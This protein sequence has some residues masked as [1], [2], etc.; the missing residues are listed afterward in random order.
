[1][2]RTQEEIYH[3]LKTV[4]GLQQ[5]TPLNQAENGLNDLSGAGDINSEDSGDTGNESDPNPEE[6]ES[7]DSPAEASQNYDFNGVRNMYSQVADDSSMQKPYKQ[8]TKIYEDEDFSV[9]VKSVNHKKSNKYELS[10][11]LYKITFHQKTQDPV[12]LLDI[13]EPLKKALIQVLSEL[14]LNYKSENHHQVFV[15]IVEKS[16]LRGLNSGNYS[17][18]APSKKVANWVCAILYNYLKSKQTLTLNESFNVKIKVLGTQH[19]RDLMDN[20]KRKRPFKPHIYH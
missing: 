8:G 10:D 1:M 9:F 20:K 5:E 14:Q 19:I 18:N 3:H 7:I 2:W 15:T 13:E 16:I 12:L 4:L 6:D 11:H 17:L